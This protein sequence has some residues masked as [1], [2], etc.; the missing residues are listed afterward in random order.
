MKKIKVLHI[1]PMYPRPSNPAF[2]IFVKSQIDSLKPLVD[3]DL[4]VLPGMRGVLPYILFIPRII[5]KLFGDFDLIHVHF[6][7]AATLIKLIYWGRKPIITSYC[8]DDLLGKRIS[9]NR[10]TV[11][12][13]IL[14]KI[15]KWLSIKDSISIVKSEKLANEIRGYARNIQVIPN[16]V[17]INKFDNINRTDARNKI[18]LGGFNGITL[19]FPAN[20]ELPVKNFKFLESVLKLL[21]AHLEY[22][23]IA[24]EGGKVEPDLVPFYY[25][26]ADVVVFT[27]LSEGSPNVIKEAMAANKTIYSS[28]CGDTKDVLKEVIN[29]KVLPLD[30]K[31]WAK[32]ISEFIDSPQS[33]LSTNGRDVLRNNQMDLASTAQRIFSL[34]K[35][36]YKA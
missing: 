13:S 12:S 1:T 9:A 16:G 8:G 10:I 23:V 35:N 26:A 18:N 7:S 6:G 17:D 5:I 32:V 15:N 19:L 27:S 3:V 29:S 28:D 14:K 21:P 36:L 22:R 25:A 31:V 4:L 2:G 11:K 30:E 34:Y 33:H 24:F 20:P